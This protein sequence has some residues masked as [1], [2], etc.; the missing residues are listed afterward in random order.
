MGSQKDM[1]SEM[2]NKHTYVVPPLPD[3]LSKNKED[4]E[5]ADAIMSNITPRGEDEQD[6]SPNMVRKGEVWE[7]HI[8][9]QL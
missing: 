3:S 6:K 1:E 9:E 4:S 7:G 8:L 2:E 5:Q